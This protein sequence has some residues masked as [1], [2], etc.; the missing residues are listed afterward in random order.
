MQSKLE[1]LYE[2]T[3]SLVSNLSETVPE[4]FERLVELREDALLDLEK[5]KTLTEMDKQMLFIVDRHHAALVQRMTELRD[6]ASEGLDKIRQSRI[7]KNRYDPDHAS[8]SYFID[9]RK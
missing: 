5:L 4:D 9:R 3:E 7:Q 6:N 2:I 1:Q 8:G